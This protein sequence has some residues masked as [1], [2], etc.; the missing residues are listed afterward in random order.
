MVRGLWSLLPQGPSILPCCGGVPRGI[1]AR[2]P[3]L[4]PPRLGLVLGG[5]GHAVVCT[6]D[7][8]KGGPNSGPDGHGAHLKDKATRC[9]G[10][11]P[12]EPYSRSKIP[13]GGF[14]LKSAS[15]A[16]SGGREKRES[17]GLAGK[18]RDRKAGRL[19]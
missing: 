10:R 19:A 16:Q 2:A 11:G 17:W 7:T 5:T 13:C 14:S 3:G 15:R 1:M 9:G 12:D 6:D 8:P 4:D 18:G